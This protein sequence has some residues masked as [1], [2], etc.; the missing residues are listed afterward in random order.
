MINQ[1]A[2]AYLARSDHLAFLIGAKSVA[3][4]SAQCPPQ[5][6]HPIAAVDKC[7]KIAAPARCARGPNELALVV[8]AH[9]DAA[10]SS[11][12]SEVLHLAMAVQK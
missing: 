11:D 5:I 8:D 7:M 2:A 12:C 10:C 1:T 3:E 9:H 4:Q 6:D